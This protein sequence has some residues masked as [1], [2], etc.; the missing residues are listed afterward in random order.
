MKTPTTNKKT[1]SAGV[2]V[3]DGLRILLGH[4]TGSQ[5]WDIPKGK[6]DPGETG[7]DGAVRELREETSMVVDPLLLVELGTF[8][9]KKTKDLNLW[10]HMV[11]IMPDPRSLDCLST[12]ETGKGM[13]KKEMDAFGIFAWADA[14][15]KVVPD[16]WR[17]LGQ[18]R[19]IMEHVRAGD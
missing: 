19:E 2:I 17:V 9:Y 14:E 7:I 18:V 16:M 6:V 13:F 3:T 12:F 5:H 1:L 4:V 10:L 15:K 11:D 8:A